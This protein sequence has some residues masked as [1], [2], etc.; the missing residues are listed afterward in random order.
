MKIALVL[1]AGGH[2]GY[3]FQLAVMDAVERHLSFDLAAS[4]L[5]VGTSVGAMTGMLLRAG[6]SVRDL[7]DVAHGRTPS[8]HADHLLHEVLDPPGQLPPE[9]PAWRPPVPMTTGPRAALRLLAGRG[10]RRNNVPAAAANLFPQGRACHEV[11]GQAA[12]SL[13]TDQPW[14][15]R[16]TWVVAMRTRDGQRAVFG[17]DRVPHTAGQAIR[18]TSAIPGWFRPVRFGGEQ[19]VDAGVRSTTNLDLVA[20]RADRIDLAIVV[21]PLAAADPRTVVV[22]APLRWLVNAQLRDEVAAV[23]A[24][25]IAVAVA[26]PPAAVARAMQG[27]PIRM[28]EER[29]ARVLAE[30][31][32]WAEAWAAD[33]PAAI[34]T[35][36]VA[37]S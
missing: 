19:Y 20:D 16:E 34:G 18:A 3:P 25:G 23:E 8:A 35:G 11:L 12:D 30:T 17:R 29:V 37:A 32:A 21:P 7:L 2:P 33:L 36:V 9:L 27:D 15:D 1:G 10:R 13:Y 26:S 5:I 6:F 22:D 31:E 28:S 4:E 14:P 24:A